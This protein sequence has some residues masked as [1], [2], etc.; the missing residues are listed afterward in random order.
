MEKDKLEPW[1]GVKIGTKTTAAF[2]KT[3]ENI[4]VGVD[5][6]CWSHSRMSLK[7]VEKKRIIVFKESWIK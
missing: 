7:N 3:E 5:G 6:F 4:G 2:V 1:R